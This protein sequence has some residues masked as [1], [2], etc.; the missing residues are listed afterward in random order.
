MPPWIWYLKIKKNAQS[1]TKMRDN[2]WNV[3]IRIK[4]DD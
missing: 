2:V 3:T 4:H 1:H